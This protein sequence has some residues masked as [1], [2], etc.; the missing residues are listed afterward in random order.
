MLQLCRLARLLSNIIGVILHIRYMHIKEI[1]IHLLRLFDATYR[2]SSVSQA[3][4]ALSISQP[5]ASQGLARLRTALGD[6]LFVRAAGGV[7][8]TPR[9][10]RMAPAVQNALDTL[11]K[12]FTETAVFD[13]RA[14]RRVFRIHMSDVGE[15]RLLPIVLKILQDEAPGIRVETFPLPLA[16]IPDALNNARIDFAFGFLPNVTGTRRAK[17]VEDRY[18]VLMRRNHPFLQQYR[19][20]ASCQKGGFSQAASGIDV[21]VD[22]LSNLKFAAVRTHTETL[23]ILHLLQLDERLRLIAQHFMALPDIVR[24][25]DLC[26]LVPR[27]LARKFSEQHSYTVLEPNL[28]FRDYVVSLHWSER[29]EHDQAI[30]WFRAQMLNYFQQ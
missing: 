25:T 6:P 18:V 23:R 12:A 16:D 10:S 5:S 8:P 7:R 3:A 1:D 19:G 2:L 22:E 27:N 29:F 26:A 9:A 30:Q 4:E 21:P 15:T 24:T 11:N 14:S 28:P 17:L 20:R 13:P